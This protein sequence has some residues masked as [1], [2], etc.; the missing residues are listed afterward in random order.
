MSNVVRRILAGAVLCGAVH[1]VPPA[2]LGEGAIAIGAS[3]NFAK[4]GF[5]FGAAVNKASADEAKEQAMATCK[6]Y[7]GAPKM[8]AICRVVMTFSQECY[9]LSF[10]PK[11]GTPGVGWAISDDKVK[12]EERAQKNCEVTAGPGRRDFCKVNQSFCDTHN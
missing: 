7:E 11:A 4:D 12:A 2:A 8:A 10:D 6:K 3:G 5:A 1:A 9:A